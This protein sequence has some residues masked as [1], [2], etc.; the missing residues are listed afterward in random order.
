ME[1]DGTQRT[2]TI[3]VS[4]RPPLKVEKD[5]LLKLCL[6]SR[7]NFYTIVNGPLEGPDHGEKNPDFPYFYP[8]RG[9]RKR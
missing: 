4:Y 2:Y 6:L 7:K 9:L 8:S 5:I 3:V 1:V